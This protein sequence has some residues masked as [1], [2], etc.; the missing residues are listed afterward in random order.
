VEKIHNEELNDLYCTPNFVR[1]MK[2]RRMRWAVHVV[3]IGEKRVVYRILVGKPEGKR[4]LGRPRRI[5]KDNIKM[6]LQEVGYGVMDWIELAQDRD[7]W[8]VLVN[9]VMNIRVP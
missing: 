5:W 4:L 3:R 2:S 1:V 6:D 9:A 8:R 7:S